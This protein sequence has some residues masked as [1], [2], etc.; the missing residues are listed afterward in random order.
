VECYIG[1]VLKCQSE[2]VADDVV[3]GKMFDIFVWNI[4]RHRSMQDVCATT[5]LNSFG[6]SF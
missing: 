2:S 4:H 3:A 6:V 5:Y 1:Y